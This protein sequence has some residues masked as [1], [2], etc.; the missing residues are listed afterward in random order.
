MFRNWNIK[1]KSSRSS[2]VRNRLHFLALL[3]L[4]TFVM[5]RTEVRDYNYL[6]SFKLIQCQVSLGQHMGFIT[7][8]EVR[9]IS[10]L[11]S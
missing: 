5:G 4:F 10:L 9:E 6:Q 3:D 7:L 11:F 2:L 8:T 1:G